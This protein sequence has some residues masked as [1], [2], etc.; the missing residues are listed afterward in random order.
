MSQYRIL[1]VEDEILIADNIKRFLNKKG[2]SVVGIAISFEEAVALY[3]EEKPDLVLLD[4]KLSGLQTGIDVA[5][6]IQD[7]EN[8][9]PFIFLTSQMDRSNVSEAK[10]TLPEAY[11]SKP[12][13]KESLYAT[14]EIVMHKYRQAH[15]EAP[16]IP[17]FDGNQHY[18]IAIDDIL[19]LQAD[20]I[21]LKIFRSGDKPIIQ[22]SSMKDFLD[23]LP[24]G[25]FIQT[26]RSFAINRKHLSGWDSQNIYL[27]EVAI[28]ISR[29]RRKEVHAYLGVG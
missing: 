18:L 29:A 17:L 19:Y 22:R 28:P 14:I 3:I 7:Q 27:G 6:F 9:K 8:P 4:I 11:L 25:Q 21:Y 23:Q 16:T 20:H 26:H 10:R 15:N 13:R 2:Y 5:Q 1:I 12:L 24:A